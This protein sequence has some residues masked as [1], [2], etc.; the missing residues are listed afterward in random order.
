MAVPRFP[1][2]LTVTKAQAAAL[3]AAFDAEHRGEG[4][5]DMF[6]NT[7]VDDKGVEW[8]VASGSFTAHQLSIIDRVL[9]RPA[10]ALS[11]LAGTVKSHD[12]EAREKMAEWKLTAKAQE[13]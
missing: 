11:R 10:I 6:S 8:A 13:K 5:K 9:A 4:Y 2:T 3:Q 12:G 7:Y 1:R